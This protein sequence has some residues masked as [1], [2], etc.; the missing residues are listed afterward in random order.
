MEPVPGYRLPYRSWFS[1]IAH[2]TPGILL[3]SWKVWRQR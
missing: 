3:N 1:L 2:A